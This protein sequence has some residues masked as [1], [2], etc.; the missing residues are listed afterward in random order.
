MQIQK[1]LLLEILINQFIPENFSFLGS[2]DI[3]NSTQL[4]PNGK[5]LDK[6]LSHLLDATKP[7]PIINHQ[8]N[9]EQEKGPPIPT[10]S[11]ASWLFDIL[12]LTGIQDW[13][14]DLQKQA[15]E[16]FTKHQALF[17]KDDM[18]LGRTNLVKHKI[19]LTDPEPFKEK[20]R[21]IPPQLY[22]EVRN[23]LNEMLKLGAIR[24]SCSPWAS[25]IVLVRKKNGKLRFCID[26]RKLNARTKKDS[27]ALLG[28]NKH[29][30]ILEVLQ[31]FQL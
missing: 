9:T 7:V 28:L 10:T 22:S 6:T 27:Y 26:L 3:L 8:V 31:S 11:D 25:A 29:L 20:F 1:T 23:H 13:P 5:I 17:S 19:V 30:I 21:S 14:S 24:K 2:E 16:L 4:F 12:D 15:K 18:D